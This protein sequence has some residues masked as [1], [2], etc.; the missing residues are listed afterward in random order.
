MN[1]NR[2][3]LKI[4]LGAALAFAIA[5]AI[6]SRRITYVLYG[7]VLCIHPI[8]GDAVGVVLDKLKAVALG[9]TCGMLVNIAFQGNTIALI[10]VGPA[11]LLL[12]GYWFDVPKRVL[13][14]S[15]TIVFTAVGS[16]SYSYQP[17]EYIALRFWNI[18]LG[19]LVGMTVNLAFWPE[20]DMDKL[21]PALARAIANIGQLYE[22]SLDDYRQGQLAA[23]TQLR[24]Q[25][26]IEIEGQ[27]SAI[28]SLLG[29]AKNELCWSPFT[30]DVPYQ[31]WIALQT[32]V[33]FLFVSVADLSLALEGG[34]GDRLYRVV[35]GELEALIGATRDTFARLSQVSALRE[36]QPSDNLFANLPALNQAISDRLSQI[37]RADNLPTD[38]D[39][40]EIKRVAAAIYGLRAIASELRDLAGV[41]ES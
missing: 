5:N 7:V 22:R 34:D 1:F 27:L 18:F 12:G 14:F 17:F 4:A 8:A 16:P 23:N 13:S 40:A 3:I 36:S 26:R 9:A 38:L 10:A 37:D 35:Q 31:R 11:M 21:A 19:A 2:Y 20:R 25:L 29:N 6:H 33:K 30:N 28:E 15:T 32:R 41:V 39:P 24:R